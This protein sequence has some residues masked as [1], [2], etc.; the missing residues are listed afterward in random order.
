[1]MKWIFYQTEE[2][3]LHNQNIIFVNRY[4]AGLR[5]V[6]GCGC[7]GEADPQVT[8][9]YALPRQREDGLWG[10]QKPSQWLE[11]IEEPVA[12]EDYNTNWFHGET[13]QE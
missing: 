13:L 3:A 5:D 2:Q 6:R 1:M 11:G 12:E 9:R 7:G 10:F 4:D 8:I